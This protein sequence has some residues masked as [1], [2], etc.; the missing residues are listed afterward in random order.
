M[1]LEALSSIDVKFFDAVVSNVVLAGGIWRVKGMQ[2]YFKR[3]I[4]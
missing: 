1:F 2:I 3:K 4:K